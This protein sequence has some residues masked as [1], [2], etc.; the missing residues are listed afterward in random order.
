M[1]MELPKLV[2]G[3]HFRES[4][5]KPRVHGSRQRLAG[6]PWIGYDIH[7]KAPRTPAPK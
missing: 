2:D 3:Y 1:V 6:K 5:E 7:I 4:I